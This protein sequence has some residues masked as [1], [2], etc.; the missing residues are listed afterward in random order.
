M[1]LALSTGHR[2]GSLEQSIA[3]RLGVEPRE[4]TTL[5]DTAL[6]DKMEHDIAAVHGEP[7]SEQHSEIVDDAET[8]VVAGAQEQTNQQHRTAQIPSRLS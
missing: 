5:A 7:T 8:V 1:D 3:K 2:L 4:A 6:T